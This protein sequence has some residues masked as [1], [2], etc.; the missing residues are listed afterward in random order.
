MAGSATLSVLRFEGD[1]EGPQRVLGTLQRLQKEGLIT[2][3]DAA[4]VVRST[5]GR[6]KVKQAHSMVGAGALGGAFWGMLI[7]LLFFMPWMGMAVGSITGALSG[8]FADYG[9]DDGFI[10]EVG[11]KIGEGDAGLFLLTTGAVVDKIADALSDE[12]FELIHT[13][14]SSEQ[15]AKLREV[16]AGE[17]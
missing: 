5:D 10:K 15:E 3:L 16:F 7:G 6:V 17:A 2:V 11:S 1:P 12:S 14:L 13:N 9:I 8:K 4:T